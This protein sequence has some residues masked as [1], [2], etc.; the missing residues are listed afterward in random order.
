MRTYEPEKQHSF[1]VYILVNM[2]YKGRAKSKFCACP[3][4]S[5]LALQY[6]CKIKEILCVSAVSIYK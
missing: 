1:R 2:A 5:K 4:T 3:E 6:W